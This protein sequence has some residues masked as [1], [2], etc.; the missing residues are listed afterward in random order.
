MKKRETQGSTKKPKAAGRERRAPQPQ[1]EAGDSRSPGGQGPLNVFFFLLLV[2][3]LAYQAASSISRIAIPERE[4]FRG[5]ECFP[6]AGLAAADACPRYATQFSLNSSLTLAV[7][8]A[9]ARYAAHSPLLRRSF[10]LGPQLLE[11][12]AAVP[13]RLLAEFDKVAVEVYSHDFEIRHILRD[14]EV[15]G[16][17]HVHEVTSGWAGT[18]RLHTRPRRAAP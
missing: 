14:A 18:Q 11:F 3:L 16:P 13:V 17:E 4:V 1:P 10:E 9:T 12:E 6:P 2:A 8:L 15:P 5:S 7:S